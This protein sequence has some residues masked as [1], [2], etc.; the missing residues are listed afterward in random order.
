L[1]TREV[2]A[3]MGRINDR[4][5]IFALSNPTSNAECTAEDAYS[6]TDGRAIF[7][8]G[9]P[10]DPVDFNG[11]RFVPGQCNNAYIFPG[12]GLGVIAC[13]AKHVTDNMFYIAA[14]TLAGL[15]SRQDLEQGLV[16]PG[17]S[18]IRDI[19]ASIAVAVAAEAYD[20]G[21]AMVPGPENLEEMI[22]EKMYEP[23]YPSFT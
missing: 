8:G 21:L 1:F 15:V 5:I 19:S 20:K 4:P 14:K 16:Y 3:E 6:V 17:L 18:K 13:R 7:A 23:V 22:R 9:S 10:F 11:R 12:V 2:L